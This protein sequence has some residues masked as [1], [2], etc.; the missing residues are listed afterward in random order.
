[1]VVHISNSQLSISTLAPRIDFSFTWYHDAMIIS[2]TDIC[3]RL[4]AEILNQ[5]GCGTEVEY[6][7]TY[8]QLSEFVTASGVNMS[9]V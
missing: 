2:G 4:S 1:M 7:G 6:F 8:S 9:F 3:Y 5:T